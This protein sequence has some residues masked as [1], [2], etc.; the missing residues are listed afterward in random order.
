MSNDRPVP[1]SPM[2]QAMAGHQF[3]LAVIHA[4]NSG[5]LDYDVDGAAR[6]LRWMW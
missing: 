5:R 1:G 2:A 4:I 6:S 3:C